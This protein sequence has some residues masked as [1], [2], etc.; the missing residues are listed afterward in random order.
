M[1]KSV[2]MNKTPITLQTYPHSIRESIELGKAD[3]T[4]KNAINIKV[5]NPHSLLQDFHNSKNRPQ[6]WVHKTKN[7]DYIKTPNAWQIEYKE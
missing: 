2:I 1:K 4:Y 3:R 6:D 7:R 5:D